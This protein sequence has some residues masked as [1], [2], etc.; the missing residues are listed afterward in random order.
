MAKDIKKRSASHIYFGVD[1]DTGVLQHIS[2]VSSGTKCNCKCAL[3]GESFE[4]RKGTQRRHHFAHVSNY[5]CMYAGEVAVYLGFS[6]VLQEFKLIRLPAITLRFPTWGEAEILQEDRSIAIDDVFYECKELA[7]PP[8]L[9]VTAGGSLLRIILNFGNYYDDSDIEGLSAEAKIGGYSTLMYQMPRVDDDNFSPEQL[10]DVIKSS[11]Q[12]QWIFSRLEEQWKDRFRSIA[13]TPKMHGH[14]CFCPL[15]KSFH[16]GKYYAQQEDCAY[17]GYNIATAPA[18]LCTAGS[19]IR[20]KA[21]FKRSEADRK[22]EIEK[23][24]LANEASL[25]RRLAMIEAQKAQRNTAPIEKPIIAAAPQKPPSPT[26]EE[27]NLAYQ[28]I[29]ASF[30]PLSDTWTMD[31]Y[32]RRWIQCKTCGK[33]KRDAEMATYGGSDGPNRGICS[34]CSRKGLW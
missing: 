13:T 8:M 16:E 22:A 24:R 10:T 15:S 18:C 5:E 27:L 12:A 25:Q 20:H 11:S 31:K 23:M 34:E 6:S 33:I 21:D 3:C 2:K 28:D 19:G 14:G 26:E 17:C 4:A 7:Y 32:G 1:K 30:D 9:R 29:V